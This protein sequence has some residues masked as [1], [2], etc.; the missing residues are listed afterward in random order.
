MVDS[1]FYSFKCFEAVG[2]LVSFLH[3]YNFQQSEVK[4]GFDNR[5]VSVLGIILSTVFTITY[6]LCFCN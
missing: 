1:F 5:V 6:F 2:C 3:L 4:V